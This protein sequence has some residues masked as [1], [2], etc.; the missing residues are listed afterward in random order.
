MKSDL[1]EAARSA[2]AHDSQIR[3]YFE[4]KKVEGKSYGCIMNAVKFKLIC[5]MFAVI[6]RQTPYVNFETYRSAS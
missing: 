1:T 2:V 3:T 5:R 6:E 4:R